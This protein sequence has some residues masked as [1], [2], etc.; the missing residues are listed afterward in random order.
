VLPHFSPEIIEE[1]L[2]FFKTP[3]KKADGSQKVALDDQEETVA[4]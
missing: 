4:E 1:L 3:L 2:R